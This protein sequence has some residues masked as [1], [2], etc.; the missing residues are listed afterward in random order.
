MKGVGR[1]IPRIGNVAYARAMSFD[2]RISR[3]DL[4]PSA[5]GFFGRLFGKKPEAPS[6]PPAPITVEEF[7]AL[8]AEAPAERRSDTLYWVRAKDQS[9]WFTASWTPE[10][11]VLSTSL[12]N[13]MYL[14]NF[15]GMIEQGL[16]LAGVLNA[17]LFDE[18]QG[19]AISPSELDTLLDFNG[20]YVTTQVAA[21]RKAHD[22][23]G[24][25]ALAPL[26]YPEDGVDL[27]PE[28]FL[29]NVVNERAVQGSAI[30]ALL[31]E[32]SVKEVQPGAWVLSEVDGGKG[33][34]KLLLRPNGWWQVWPAWG[35]LPFS[36]VAAATLK[37]ADALH[38]LGGGDLIFLG[39]LFDAALRAEVQRRIDGLGLEFEAWTRTL[40]GG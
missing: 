37:A 15:A 19:R 9:P 8:M 11:V 24:A 34:T 10:A 13:H 1:L 40:P 35:Q 14:R 17:R 31:P 23:A 36:K 29:F 4:Y 2:L 3:A 12:S 6:A 5:P 21:W 16:A 30:A 22:H 38:T 28:Y 27:V 33:T 20:R 18:T 7:H 39:R 32:L 25:R 26:E